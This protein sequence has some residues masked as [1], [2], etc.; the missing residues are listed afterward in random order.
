MHSVKYATA[1]LS[2][3]EFNSRYRCSF[4]LARYV[5]G[6]NAFASW[7]ASIDAWPRSR[8]SPPLPRPPSFFLF[9]L[10]PLTYFVISKFVSPVR[11][12]LIEFM[13]NIMCTCNAIRSKNPR[14]YV[15]NY[16]KPYRA[17]DTR[18][19]IRRGKVYGKVF[20]ILKS[21]QCRQWDLSNA[22]LNV[23]FIRS[24]AIV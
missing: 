11:T 19:I 15:E 9:S 24:V 6:S 17:R 8:H 4:T 10:M 18:L 1:N 12:T 16:S 21:R 20:G 13:V 5:Y 14:N 3:F 7:R 2:F 23:T 22:T